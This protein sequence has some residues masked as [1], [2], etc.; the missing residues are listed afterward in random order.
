VYVI[1]ALASGL[2]LDRVRGQRIVV[3]CLVSLGS[4]LMLPKDEF[5]LQVAES[6]CVTACTQTPTILRVC[7][8]EGRPA[9]GCDVGIET[10]VER[11]LDRFR[12]QRIAEGG[13]QSS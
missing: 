2:V 7:V 3:G 4:G 10:D 6:G 5:M 13:V 8:R 11:V 9:S 1:S 12:G